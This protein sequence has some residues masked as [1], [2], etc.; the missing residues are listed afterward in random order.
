MNNIHFDIQ[1]EIRDLYTVVKERS[2]LTK[3]PQPGKDKR[4]LDLLICVRSRSLFSRLADTA[5]WPG[6]DEGTMKGVREALQSAFDCLNEDKEHAEEKCLESVRD[7]VDA[8]DKFITEDLPQIRQKQEV[9][10]K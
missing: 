4:S 7:R 8:F 3:K 5:L 1:R 2:D 6:V 10:A 9:L